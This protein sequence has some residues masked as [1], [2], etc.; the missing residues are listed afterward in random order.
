M[1]CTQILHEEIQANKVT[2]SSPFPL[3]FLMSVGKNLELYLD[4]RMSCLSTLLVASTV[5]KSFIPTSA[6][7]P[8]RI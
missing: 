3:N 8:S 1:K 2:H 7:R 5:R 6:L 4:T